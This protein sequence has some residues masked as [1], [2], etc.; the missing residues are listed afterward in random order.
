MKPK[1][2]DFLQQFCYSMHPDWE[3]MRYSG[4]VKPWAVDGC[5]YAT[6]KAVMVAYHCPKLKAQKPA[7]RVPTTKICQEILPD[8]DKGR[9]HKWPVNP[10]TSPCLDCPGKDKD[11]STCGG[12]G[13]A[14]YG[15]NSAWVAR[16]YYDLIKALPNVYYKYRKRKPNS[17]HPVQFRYD[18][19]VG[20]VM[21]VGAEG[22]NVPKRRRRL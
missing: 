20:A 10:P 6:D 22:E 16:H 2:P 18:G 5:W 4:M 12:T 9:W 14:L 15:V 3:S 17:R 1:P 21:P 13:I 11:C 8:P 19:G 7:G